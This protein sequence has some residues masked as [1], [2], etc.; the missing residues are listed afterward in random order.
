VAGRILEARQGPL[1]A[2]LDLS[3]AGPDDHPRAP[4]WLSRAG[5]RTAAP[6]GPGRLPRRAIPGRRPR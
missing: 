6:S 3:L 5:R 2:G 1:R 4:R